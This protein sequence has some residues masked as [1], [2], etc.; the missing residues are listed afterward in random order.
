[1]YDTY[2]NVD[3]FH[4]GFAIDLDLVLRVLRYVRS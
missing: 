3:C 1:M 4:D 2:L